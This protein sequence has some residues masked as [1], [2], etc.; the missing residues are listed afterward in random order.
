MSRSDWIAALEAAVKVEAT[1][2]WLPVSAA[3]RVQESLYYIQYNVDSVR[4]GA[5]HGQDC[6]LD[7]TVEGGACWVSKG[8]KVSM[9]GLVRVVVEGEG[10]MTVEVK[11]G[12]PPA[13]RDGLSIRPPSFLAP[14]LEWLK[15]NN[16]VGT[17]VGGPD[18]PLRDRLGASIP[19]GSGMGSASRPR[20]A[21]GSRGA[22]GAGAF[23]P[24][25]AAVG[26]AVGKLQLRERQAQAI[27]LAGAPLAICWGPPGT[28]KTTTLA[29][30]VAGL[31]ARGERV[32]VVAPT[33]VAA[34]GACL[35]IDRQWPNGRLRRQGDLLRNQL[36]Q[37]VA[38]FED[39][40]PEL[41]IWVEE[42]AYFSR[43]QVNLQRANEEARRDI[44]QG[45]GILRDKAMLKAVS[46]ADSLEALRE[47]WERRQTELIQA[48][49]VVVSTVRGAINRQL[50]SGF[51]HL[52]IDEASMVSRSDGLLL[53]AQQE[54]GVGRRGSCL[55]FGDHK[56]LGPV[57]PLANH[58]GEA[59]G[60]ED[61]ALAPVQLA[62]WFEV[63][64][65]STVMAQPGARSRTVMLNE[66]SRMNPTLCAIVS[67]E[68]YEGDLLATDAAPPGGLP[69]GL[70][71]G[72]CLLDP[73][74]NQPSIPSFSL[75]YSKVSGPG[76]QPQSAAYTV[77][78]ARLLDDN[79]VEVLVCSPYRAQ[80]TLIRRGLA[81]RDRI[82]AGT[83]HRMQGQEASVCIFDPGQAAQWFIKA[84]SVA[85]RLV[86]VAASR[87][88]D[89]LVICNA[90]EFVVKNPLLVP[91]LRVASHLSNVRPGRGAKYERPTATAKSR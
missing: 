40:R 65:L 18:G 46:I 84:S 66:Q 1:P 24:R 22:K 78:L 54:K 72:V 90:A 60:V 5:L 7:S 68:S 43:A 35:A 63:D 79:G 19:T 55:L 49:Q 34:D 58:S 23:G 4:R 47:A 20:G 33:R 31:V 77:A 16:S 67:A 87:A 28:G 76:L 50:A 26:G 2:I 83:I 36:P 57:P 38:E 10:A 44:L 74:V 81:D 80:A 48:A 39:Q 12:R 41:L 17:G 13:A 51:T 64:I 53:L 71:S 37:L 30:L 91:Y 86:N 61:R 14:A 25:D 89:V 42:E 27:E 15:A 11:A 29:C 9:N 6:R 69:W 21:A 75:P 70:P 59:E 62:P 45:S 32:L 88:K 82:R 8:G 52:I 73:T 85:P 3:R 56:Q